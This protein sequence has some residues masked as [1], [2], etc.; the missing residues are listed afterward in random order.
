MNEQDLKVIEAMERYGGSFVVALAQAARRADANNLD[1]L[2]LAF[3]EYWTQYMQ[4][5]GMK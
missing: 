1:R 4:M 5:A 2:K 3:P